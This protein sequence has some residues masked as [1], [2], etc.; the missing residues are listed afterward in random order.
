[1]TQA[2]GGE[3]GDPLMPA[4]YALLDDVYLTCTPDRTGPFSDA[5]GIAL[6]ERANVRLHLGKKRAWNAAGEEPSS[7][8][9]TLP[10]DARAA[11]WTIRACRAGHAGWA[12]L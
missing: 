1:M 9:L 8:L 10:P 2:E 5:L 12:F 4:L 3:Q 7:L 6:W 11:A